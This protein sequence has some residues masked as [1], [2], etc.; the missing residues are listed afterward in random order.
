MM[1]TRDSI[2]AGLKRM[3][4]REIRL[5]IA[6]TAPE[7]TASTHFGGRPDLPGDFIWPEYTG[8]GIDGE[9][10]KRPL[11][12]LAQFRCADLAELDSTGLLPCD[13]LLSFFYELDSQPWGYDPADAGCARVYWFRECSALAPAGFPPELAEDLRLPA[14]G[15]T[16]RAAEGLPGLEDYELAHPNADSDDFYEVRAMFGSDAPEISSKLLGWPDVIQ[17]NMTRECALVRRGCYL[18]GDWSEVPEAAIREAEERSLEDWL[19]LFQLDTV[20]QGDFELMFGDCG[21]IYF[22]IRREDLAARRFDRVWLILQC[23]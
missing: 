5:E 20:A 10:K 16:M 12:F 17:N 8:E 15:I 22:Y 9:R 11:A 13:G 23:C 21:R 2:L 14:I 3:L 1:D 4:R 19:L 6:G 18:G 7:G